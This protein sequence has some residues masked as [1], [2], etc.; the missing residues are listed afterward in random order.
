MRRKKF[1]LIIMCV[2]AIVL[3]HRFI[4]IHVPAEGTVV[5]KAEEQEIYIEESLSDDE[6]VA[7]KKILWGK[8]RWSESLYGYPACGFY[9]EYAVIIGDVRYMLALD[10]CGTLCVESADVGSGSRF[11]M[12]ISDAERD[13]FEEIFMSRLNR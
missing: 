11:Y 9:Q 6:V 13:I 7:V 5:F 4:Y 10:S 1:L 12:D 8:I 3:L 2:A